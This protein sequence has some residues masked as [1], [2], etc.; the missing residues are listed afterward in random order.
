MSGFDFFFTLYGLV[1]GLSVVEVVAGFARL[2]HGHRG[3]RVGW[4]VPM[5]AIFMLLDVASFWMSA[6][7]RLKDDAPSYAMLVIGL[8]VS[9]LYYVAATAVFPRD[10]AEQPDFDAHYLANRRLVLGAVTIAGILAFELLPS[11]TPAGRA[12]RLAFWT[13]A[14]IWQPL[15]F[16]ACVGLAMATRHVRLNQLLLALLML[17]YLFNFAASFR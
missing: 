6:F 13:S 10:F 12:E 2:A 11:L 9:G 3:L 4:L 1:L 14:A 5:L 15:T 8:T 16:F 7:V 17:P